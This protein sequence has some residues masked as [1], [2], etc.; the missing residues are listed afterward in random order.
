VCLLQQAF[1]INNQQQQFD[2][3][4]GKLQPIWVLTPLFG[5]LLFVCLYVGATL[6]YPGGSQADKHAKGFSWIHNYWCNLLSENAINE[7]HNPARPLAITG[8]FIL[9]L[10]LAYFWWLFPQKVN[11]KK[12]TR[13]L[14]QISGSLAMATGMFIFTN[15]HDAIINVAGF[16]GLFAMAGT[17][18]GLRKLQ[19]TKLFWLGIFN[20]LLVA[21][22]NVLYHGNGWLSY[23]PVVQKITFLFFLLWICFIDIQLYR[24][25]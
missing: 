21:L 17:F 9:S 3:S 18:I 8:M 4:P 25:V 5:I 15:L 23:L 24:K 20:L 6:F 14:I 2:K 16:C 1:L 12:H 13:R 10:S 7:Q 22:N 19:W 11:F